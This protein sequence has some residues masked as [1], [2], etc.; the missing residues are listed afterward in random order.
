MIDRR[1]FL[2]GAAVAATGTAAG[3]VLATDNPFTGM[4]TAE[5]ADGERFTH[6][7]RRVAIL[8]MGAVLHA[9][10]NEVREVHVER[11]GGNE[12]LTH[13]LPF[14]TFKRPRQ[15]VEAVID[16]EDDGLLII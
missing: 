14:G 2:I 7:G 15:L 5:A 3:V 6:R 4:P 10:V 13:L 9:T 16:A 1:R 8:P 11:A 12:Y